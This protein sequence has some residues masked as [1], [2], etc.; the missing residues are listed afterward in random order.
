MFVLLSHLVGSTSKLMW[1]GVLM[2]PLNK[3]SRSFCRYAA[4]YT[5]ERSQQGGHQDTSR[6]FNIDG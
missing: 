1:S 4:P 6:S 5:W 2:T 3:G